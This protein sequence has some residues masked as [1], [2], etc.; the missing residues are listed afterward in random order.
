MLE[1]YD[2]NNAKKAQFEQTK[3]LRCLSGTIVLECPNSKEEPRASLAL[4]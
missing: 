1:I 2:Y 4:L 3:K